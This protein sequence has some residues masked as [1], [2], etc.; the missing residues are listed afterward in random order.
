M[1]LGW[2]ELIK[3]AKDLTSDYP[4]VVFIGGAAVS[5][6]AGLL[7]KRFQE[8]SHDIDFYLSLTGKAAMRNRFEMRS[9]PRLQKDSANIGGQDADIYV[10][11]QH[12]LAVPYAEVYAHSEE[13]DGIRVACLEHLLVL[14]LDAAWDRRGSAKGEKDMRDLACIMALMNTPHSKRL[15]P[16]LTDQR[17][18]AL[19]WAMGRKDL[20]RLLGLNP[21]EGSRFREGLDQNM[22]KVRRLYEGSVGAP[23]PKVPEPTPKR[24]KPRRR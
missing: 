4:D 19:E 17:V 18:E 3:I 20:T 5:T 11:R 23:K 2:D 8:S 13:I 1:E 7:G 16:Y 15:G 9:D 12:G 22:D 10:E 21:H 14:K 6:H 24:L